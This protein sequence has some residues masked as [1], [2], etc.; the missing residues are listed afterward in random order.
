MRTR[1][2]L[3]LFFA[4]LIGLFVFSCPKENDS[5]PGGDPGD[6]FQTKVGTAWTYKI[7]LGEV[8]P[9]KYEEVVWPQGGSAIRMATRGLFLASFNKEEKKEFSLKIRVKGLASK[10]GKIEYP[11]GVELEIEQDEFGIFEYHKQVFFAATPH[12]GF[13]AHRVETRGYDSP[14]APS[15]SWGGW[16]ADDGYTMP[17]VFFAEK[18]G[19]RISIGD[20]SPDSLLFI[21]IEKSPLGHSD[22]LHFQRKVEPSEKKPGNDLGDLEKGFT[23]DTW[24]A[25][26]KGLVYLVQKI[27][28]EI[29][30]IWTLTGFSQ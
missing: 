10:Q 30:M 8:K 12:G 27:D 13:T 6:Y 24:F 28:G 14:G 20:K 1:R 7:T 16:G 25:R 19:T 11:I 23:E 2:L 9:L 15:N 3:V 17:L 26:G 21:G 18:P 4:V 29:S 5:Q 22:S